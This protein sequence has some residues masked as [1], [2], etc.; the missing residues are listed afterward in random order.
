MTASSTL[1]ISGNPKGRA[2]T[3]G[4]WTLQVLG[5]AAFIAAGGF[6]LAAAPQMVDIF[7]QIGVGQWFR[8]VTGIVEVGGGLLLLV[9]SR[10]AFG[11]LLLA[12][13]MIFAAATHLFVIG[14]SPVPALILFLVTAGVAWLRRG[15]F[16]AL[17]GR[18]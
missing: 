8:V 7:N 1:A 13:T 4:V 11:G 18:S 16:T 17:R 5:A 6:K 15:Q 9:P 10:A 12:V 3:I 14:G 2:A